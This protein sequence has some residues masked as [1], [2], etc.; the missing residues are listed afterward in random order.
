[1][2][3]YK[4]LIS[5]LL[6]LFMGLGSC[7]DDDGD[8]ESIVSYP[9]LR[10]YLDR[11]E[12]EAALR[13]YDFDLSAVEIVYVDAINH[14]DA[15]YCGYGYSNYD[16]NGLR[17][18]EMSKAAG[19]GFLDFT[20][21]Q[22]ESFVFH[23]IGHAFFNRAHDDG[24]QC[25]GSALS[26]MIPTPYYST[27][28]ESEEE[29]RDYYISELID[30]LTGVDKCIDYGQDWTAD[31]VLYAFAKGDSRWMFDP[32]DGQY[33]GQEKDGDIL[34]IASVSIAQGDDDGYWY[35]QL[36]NPT[37]PECAEVTFKVRMNSE[38]LSGPGA[39]IGVRVYDTPPG[40][41]GAEFR[42]TLLLSPDG[43][44]VSGQLV[45]RDEEVTIPCY[46]RSSQ[47]VFLF[48][49]MMAGTEGTVNFDDLQVIVKPQ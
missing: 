29:K 22:R 33:S 47:L 35:T 46:T 48:V 9:D 10:V 44:P 39:T 23:E 27:Y 3:H 43:G 16:G 32:V 1:M 11:F 18:I 24:L 12:N 13:G 42:Q 28:M 8:K 25:D 6:F 2:R 4:L 45:D 31:P 17:R 15:S 38:M 14:A 37:I 19:C 5:L 36:I 34:S 41:T 20:D 49:V 30:P 21:A 7:D 26:L 40:R